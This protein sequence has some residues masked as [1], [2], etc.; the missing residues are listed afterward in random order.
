MPSKTI[1]PIVAN[2]I[3]ELIAGGES[4]RKASKI[5][6][7]SPSTFLRECSNNDDLAERYTRNIA[8][9]AEQYASEIVEIADEEVYTPAEAQRQKLRVDARKWIACKLVPQRYGDNQRV[10]VNVNVD[11]ADRMVRARERGVID[12]TP[13]DHEALAAADPEYLPSDSV[14]KATGGTK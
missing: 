7:V 6:G 3:L 2:V 9:R 4:L 5:A 10:D 14:Q 1:N 11:I 8:I 12:V 13:V